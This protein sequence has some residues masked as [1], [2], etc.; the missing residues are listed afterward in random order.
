MPATQLH[1]SY[2]P[3]VNDKTNPLPCPTFVKL[4]PTLHEKENPDPTQISLLSFLDYRLDPKLAKSCRL[5]IP[6]FC[7]QVVAEH[8]NNKELFHGRLIKCLKTKFIA[9]VN[10]SFRIL[11]IFLYLCYIFINIAWDKHG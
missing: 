1:Q 10:D 6:K 3:I 7:S 11:N 8:A 2:M 9:K 4:P 5:D